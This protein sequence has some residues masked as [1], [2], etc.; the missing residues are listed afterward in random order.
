MKEGKPLTKSL[1]FVIL[2][3][4]QALS[5]VDRPETLLQLAENIDVHGT[6]FSEQARSS[7]GA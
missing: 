3:D 2:L 7:I 4:P 6:T 1:R 5:G